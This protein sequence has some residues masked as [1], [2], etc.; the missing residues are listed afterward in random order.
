[1][2][3]KFQSKYKISNELYFE[4]IKQSKDEANFDV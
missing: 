4:L 2:I 3:D 1:M